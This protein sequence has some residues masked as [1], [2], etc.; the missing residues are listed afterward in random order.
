MCVRT[1]RVKASLQ[2]PFGLLFL[3]PCKHLSIFRGGNPAPN[4]PEAHVLLPGKHVRNEGSD[5]IFFFFPV[6]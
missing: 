6:G 2:M 4:L 3:L 5:F 1:R